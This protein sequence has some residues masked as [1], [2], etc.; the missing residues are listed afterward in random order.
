MD[1]RHFDWDEGNARP[2]FTHTHKCSD[3]VMDT[4][5]S[6]DQTAKPSSPLVDQPREQEQEKLTAQV[7]VSE[8]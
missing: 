8:L 5:Y 2:S 6:N 7:M 1:L 4:A 3:E